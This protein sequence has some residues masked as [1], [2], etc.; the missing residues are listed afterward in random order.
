MHISTLIMHVNPLKLKKMEAT[1]KNINLHVETSEVT[2]FLQKV[3]KV[4]GENLTE[5]ETS[6]VGDDFLD[7]EPAVVFQ[8]KIGSITLISIESYH[9]GGY[10]QY[11]TVSNSKDASTLANATAKRI[12]NPNFDYEAVELDNGKSLVYSTYGHMY[13]FIFDEAFGTIEDWRN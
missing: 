13:A 9:T 7:G 1:K 11:L 2:K 10:T 12:I 4:I 6:N 8:Y 3:S 5:V